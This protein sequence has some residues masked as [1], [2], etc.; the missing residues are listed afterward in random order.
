MPSITHDPHRASLNITKAETCH[1]A[2]RFDVLP[3]VH[4][5]KDLQFLYRSIGKTKH[6]NQ[7]GR[8]AC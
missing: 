7:V 3:E 2:I 6:G 8:Y 4:Y 5:V 1:K